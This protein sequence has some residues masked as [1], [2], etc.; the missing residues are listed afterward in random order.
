MSLFNKVD[1]GV[2]YL[3]DA[4][5]Q[6]TSTDGSAI[7]LGTDTVNIL[8]RPVAFVLTAGARTYAG[9]PTVDIIIQE[10][11]TSGFTAPTTLAS[12]TQI[13]TTVAAHEVIFATPT[14]RYLR[15]ASTFSAATT[16]G[17][18]SVVCL[19]DKRTTLS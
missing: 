10:D 3:L 12:F 19:Y 7:D 9:S 6:T 17:A 2:K 18:Y 16:T 13:A 11:S 15:Y 1:Q 5:A 14:K 8:K 4:V